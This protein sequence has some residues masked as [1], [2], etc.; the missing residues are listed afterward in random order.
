MR[1]EAGHQL[2]GIVLFLQAYVVL[3]FGNVGPSHH[4]TLLIIE[5]DFILSDLEKGFVCLTFFIIL[6]FRLFVDILVL[7][8]F[9]LT[10]N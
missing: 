4:S 9:D 10:L 3:H 2:D 1:D 7:K 6:F 8:I 5:H